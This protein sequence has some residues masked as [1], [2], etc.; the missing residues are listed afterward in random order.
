MNAFIAVIY[1]PPK[2]PTDGFKAI[3]EMLQANLDEVCN[4]SRSPDI[5]ILGDF[6]LPSIDWES[7]ALKSGVACDSPEASQCLLDFLD[8]NFLTQV[9][10]KPTRESNILDLI[11]TNKPQDILDIT[12]TD[13]A[14]SE[15]RLVEG[16][17][18]YNP[19]STPKEEPFPIDPLSFRSIDIHESDY[20]QINT[21]LSEVDWDFLHDLL[22]DD[23]SGEL[24]LELVR[25]TTLQICLLHS[26]PKTPPSGKSVGRKSRGNIHVLKRKRRRLNARISA[27]SLRNPLSPI[28]PKLVADASLL[29]YKIKESVL[30]SLEAREIK[31]VRNIKLNP[32]YFFSYAKKFAKVKSSVSPLK[33]IHGIL[34]ADPKVKAEILQDQYVKVFSDPSAADIDQCTAQLNPDYTEKL[35]NIEFDQQD[36]ADAIKEL[37]PYSSTPDGDIPARVLTR[38]STQLSKPL[39]L[40]WQKSFQSGVIPDSLKN[41]YITPVFKKG[42]KTD[43][44]NYR[45][46]S[47]TSHVIKIFE[48][49]LRKSLVSHM[50]NNNLLS[51]KQHGF[52]KKR[53]CLTQLIDH[54][55]S[56]LKT[57]NGG[58]E[59]DTIYLDY[60]KAFDKVDH[61]ILL[62]KL[63][64]Y[65][66][67]GCALKWI[68]QFLLNRLQT[69]VVEGQ[70]SSFQ[71][72]IS[73]VPQGTVLGPILFILYINDELFV[74]LAADGKIFA[75]DTKL[76]CKIIDIIS[77]LMLQEDLNNVIMWS[78][79]NNM[80]LNG[81][82]FEVLN[83]TLNKSENLRKLPF[84]AQYLQYQLSDGTIIQPSE[85][86]RDLGVLLS[87]DCSWSPHVNQMLISARKVSAWVFSVFRTRS[88]EPMLQLYKTMV[89]SKLE[90]CCP[91]WDP[92]KI[93]D[94]EAIEKIQRNFTRR[95]SNCKNLNY[96]D[97]LKNLKL[98]SQ[99]PTTA[100][101]AVY[102]YPYMEDC[103]WTCSQRHRHGFQNQ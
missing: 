17:L 12:A 64:K 94:I 27:I 35:E 56:I 16:L 38:C 98:M 10:D 82:K 3:L 26:P 30:D 11:I 93:Q 101:R 22:H 42:D 59:V 77:H 88:V 45:P 4:D 73:G 28:L 9:V 63:K 103:Q 67:D 6:N 66:V 2:S 13:T 95:L 1:R 34:Q 49:V 43:A 25:L 83:Y 74:L 41:Q 84:S 99:V 39:Y 15:H 97:R 70:K 31:A 58:H 51:S 102:H 44:A 72:V 7:T 76:V 71:L 91:V 5:Y 87:N 55:D 20:E 40:L 92:S 36:I 32:R 78:M 24:F 68:E 50:E 86:V 52:R 19:T 47:I 18:G 89:R 96:W 54:V 37:D 14:L 100:K 46:I 61:Q 23:D 21:K 69:V 85:T 29:T 75:D 90:Y 53:S 8:K 57:L 81:K 65:G 62:R 80:E 33:D 60:A 48:R 79:K